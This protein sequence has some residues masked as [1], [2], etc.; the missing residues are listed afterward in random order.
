MKLSTFIY[1]CL[2]LVLFSC[3]AEQDNPLVLPSCRDNIKNQNEEE[4]DCGGV[5]AA[6]E[7]VEP[8][9]VPCESILWDNLIQSDYFA[10]EL[11]SGDYICTQESDYYEIFIM[12]DSYSE[13]TIWIYGKSLPKQSTIYEIDEWYDL[14][15][16]EASIKYLNFYSYLAQSGKL[17]LTY[18]N[19]KWQVEI[20]PV[21]L[22][23]QGDDITFSGRILC[24]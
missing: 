10:M 13:M 9:A 7:V 6:C 12:P 2:A 11:E 8:Y 16:G 19:Q 1:F 22:S 18:S 24:K 14:G 23:G 17:Y 21:L 4:V 3:L 5:C 20:C 15:P